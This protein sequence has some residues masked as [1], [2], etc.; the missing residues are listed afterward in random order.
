MA[1]AEVNEPTTAANSRKMKT[2][3]LSSIS[4]D[5]RRDMAIVKQKYDTCA[6]SA[7]TLRLS[8]KHFSGHSW[9]IKA[10]RFLF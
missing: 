4:I 1:M 5:T 7:R 3:V 8:K 6:N 9:L 2:C 10:V